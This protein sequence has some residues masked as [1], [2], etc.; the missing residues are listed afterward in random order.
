MGQKQTLT[1]LYF[2]YDNKIESFPDQL[3]SCVWTVHTMDH[4]EAITN[5][6]T[7]YKS[8]KHRIALKSIYFWLETP[9]RPNET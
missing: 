5:S 1:R 7:I 4:K 3:I 6:K 8:Q 9:G 2:H